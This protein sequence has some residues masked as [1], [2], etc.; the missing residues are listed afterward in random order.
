M[1]L[2]LRT[3]RWAAALAVLLL[4]LLVTGSSSAHDLPIDQLTLFPDVTSGR[5]RGQVLF[6]PKL[7]RANDAEG[8]NVIAP[9]VVAFLQQNLALE[10]DGKR[11]EPTFSVRE[12]WTL[13]GA[14]AG[15]SVMLDAT[16]PRG[17]KELR[18]FAGRPLRALAVTVEA[19]GPNGRSSPENALLLGGEWTPP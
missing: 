18:V 2:L 16:F 12:L 6:D 8:A 13:N 14:V 19:V 17:A 15:D 11:I 4:T 10:V 1:H 5:L 3:A 9:R 7:T